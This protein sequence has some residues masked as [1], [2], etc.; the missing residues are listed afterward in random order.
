MTLKEAYPLA[1]MA[2]G[3]MARRGNIEVLKPGGARRIR[4]NETAL[5]MI[6]E[7]SARVQSLQV[8][9]TVCHFSLNVGP[10]DFQTKLA[11]V[12]PTA[13]AGCWDDDPASSHHHRFHEFFCKVHS[14]VPQ[15]HIPLCKNGFE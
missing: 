12:L 4:R 14:T 5:F 8:F 11:G 2:V 9:C 15:A 1:A 7:F 13:L 6:A 3:G 10:L